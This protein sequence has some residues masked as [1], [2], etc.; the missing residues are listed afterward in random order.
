MYALVFGF[1][2]LS[3]TI[4]V[5]CI[6]LLTC[7]IC[8]ILHIAVQSYSIIFNYIIIFYFSIFYWR[9]FGL[10]LAIINKFPVSIFCMYFRGLFPLFLSGI[11][12]VELL[13]ICWT[14]KGHV[15]TDFSIYI[16]W[17]CV[18]CLLFSDKYY[19]YDLQLYRVFF[20]FWFLIVKDCGY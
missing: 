5:N 12:S 9:A 1:Y 16:E 19:I 20:Y 11:W 17:S 15:H 7:N 3:I 18:L 8:L 14:Q 6:Y 10:Q 4:L 2:L 13:I